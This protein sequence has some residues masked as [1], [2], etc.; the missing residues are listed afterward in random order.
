METKKQ[1]AYKTWASKPENKRA[2]KEYRRGRYLEKKTYLDALKVANGC[3]DCGN[4]FPS[5]CLDFDHRDPE[6]K[7]ANVSQLH[8]C[9]WETL[10]KEVEKCDIVCAN[11]HRLRTFPDARQ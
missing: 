9:S 1:I 2:R 6:N 8:S 11:C 4:L 7:V 3:D 5:V 10:K